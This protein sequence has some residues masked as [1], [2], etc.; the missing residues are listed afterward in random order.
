MWT[1]TIESSLSRGCPFLG[2][3]S[4][5]E[6]S[7]H[8]CDR[9]RAWLDVDSVIRLDV[10]YALAHHLLQRSDRRGEAEHAYEAELERSIQRAS[11]AKAGDHPR[12]VR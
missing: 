12:E 4:R 9:H 7:Q 3:A 10:S 1:R 8:A 5:I 6:P 11:A 2:C